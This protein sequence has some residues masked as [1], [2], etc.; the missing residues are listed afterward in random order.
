MPGGCLFF[1]FFT[2]LL[3]LHFISNES[4]IWKCRCFSKA[5]EVY[6]RV[7]PSGSRHHTCALWFFHDALQEHPPQSS[8]Y[9]RFEPS[10]ALGEVVKRVKLQADCSSAMHFHLVVTGQD[11]AS[12][13]NKPKCP[14]QFVARP[15]LVCR[16]PRDDQQPC[17]NASLPERNHNRHP[18]L[19]HFNTAFHFCSTATSNAIDWSL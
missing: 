19:S 5:Y 11:S 10:S 17:Q 18:V 1:L 14:L 3:V 16:A 9:F 7:S 15:G 12:V 13:R 2:N 4:V 8:S 6:L